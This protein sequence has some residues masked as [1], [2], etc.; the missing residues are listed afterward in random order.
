M[1][2]SVIISIIALLIS[3][4]GVLIAL[5]AYFKRRRCVLCDDFGDENYYDDEDFDFFED[6]LGE[7][8]DMAQEVVEDA[9]EKV[10]EVVEKVAPRRGRPKKTIS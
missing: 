9:K 3:M 1:R 8:K 7:I 2:K 5:V 10:E 4:I 6:E